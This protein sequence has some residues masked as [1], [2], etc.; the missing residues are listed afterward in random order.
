M[1]T[2]K[3]RSAN[4]IKIDPVKEEIIWAICDVI[5]KYKMSEEDLRSAQE[6]KQ[7]F[8]NYIDMKLDGYCN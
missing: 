3:K 4:V 8:Y 5:Y 2:K 1:S 7:A 6:V